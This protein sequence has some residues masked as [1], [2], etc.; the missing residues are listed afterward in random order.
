MENNRVKI[1]DPNV[2]CLN[3]IKEPLYIFQGRYGIIK[4][5]FDNFIEIEC[6]E[7]SLEKTTGNRIYEKEILCFDQIE[8]IKTK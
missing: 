6:E 4:T 1:L 2:I 8:I 3:F 7:Y 5:I